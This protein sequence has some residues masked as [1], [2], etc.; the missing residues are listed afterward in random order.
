MGPIGVSDQ[1][2]LRMSA[3]ISPQP[4]KTSIPLVVTAPTRCLVSRAGT[5]IK[6]RESTPFRRRK[7]GK[8]D[9]PWPSF[10]TR[11]RVPEIFLTRAWELCASARERIRLSVSV[12]RREKGS[13]KVRRLTQPELEV[14]DSVG[15]SPREPHADRGASREQGKTTHAPPIAPS[16]FSPPTGGWRCATATS[17]RASSSSASKRPLTALLRAYSHR[18]HSRSI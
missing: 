4:G 10:G 9:T 12:L 11:Y 2:L 8:I 6:M 5:S 16:S 1:S 13:E 15:R 18:A 3:P 14:A 7:C 17:P